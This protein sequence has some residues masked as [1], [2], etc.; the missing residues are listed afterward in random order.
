VFCDNCF[1]D[2]GFVSIHA[3]LTILHQ[4]C[5]LMHGK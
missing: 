1:A 5:E 4:Q 2:N 3:F